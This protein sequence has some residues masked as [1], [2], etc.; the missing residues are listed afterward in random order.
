MLLEI[1]LLDHGVVGLILSAMCCGCV[2]VV[3]CVCQGVVV[4]VVVVVVLWFV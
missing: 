4:G 2:V 3:F 1:D